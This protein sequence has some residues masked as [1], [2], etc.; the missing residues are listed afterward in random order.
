MAAR[1]VPD[2]WPKWL[3]YPMTDNALPP[4]VEEARKTTF[5]IE[6]WTERSLKELED[7]GHNVYTFGLSE[8]KLVWQ[9]PYEPRTEA[10]PHLPTA[11]TPYDASFAYVF[12]HMQ[13]QRVVMITTSVAWLV[14]AEAALR[15]HPSKQFLGISM[16]PTASLPPLEALLSFPKLFAS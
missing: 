15:L 10:S 1:I 4:E 9:E 7:R 11:D 12:A 13:A 6:R 8:G 3:S 14:L 5:I 2:G 16:P